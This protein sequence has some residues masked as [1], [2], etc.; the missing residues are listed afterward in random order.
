V[1]HADP[2]C[3]DVR[4][5]LRCTRPSRTGSGATAGVAQPVED[6]P[7]DEVVRRA[8]ELFGGTG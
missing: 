4:K 5:G 6:V 7:H 8:A 2:G 3:S 1:P